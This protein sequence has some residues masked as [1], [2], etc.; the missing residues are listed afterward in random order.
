MPT[1]DNLRA[2]G[3]IVVSLCCLC[4]QMDET[5]SHLILDCK[6]AASLWAWFSAILHCPIDCTSICVVLTICEK[7][8]C[9]QVKDIDLATVINIFWVIWHCQNQCRFKNKII[10]QGHA[11]SLVKAAS[12]MSGSYSKGVMANSMV[13]LSS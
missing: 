2:K 3:C 9:S 4:G 1:D 12:H 11:I 13:D 10:S 8:W 7:N 5:G 6:F